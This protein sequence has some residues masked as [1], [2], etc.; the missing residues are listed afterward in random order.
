MVRQDRIATWK[1]N[2]RALAYSTVGTPDYIAPEVFGQNGYSKECD[3]WSLGAI[4]YECLVGYP[5]FCSDHPHETYQKI[6]NWRNT[7]FIPEE[8]ILSEEAEDLL[9]GF[10]CDASERIT[11]EQLVTHPFFKAV[12]WDLMR[13]F[14]PPFVPSLVSITDTSYFS[15]EDVKDIPEALA[16]PKEEQPIG[17]GTM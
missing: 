8:V 16:A 17:P 13:T 11:F 12:N 9:Q 3:W 2:R 5:P 7:L 6:M 10:L 4:M 15:T 1:K 14:Q